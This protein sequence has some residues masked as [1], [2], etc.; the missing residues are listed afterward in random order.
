[1]WQVVMNEGLHECPWMCYDCRLRVT[2]MMEGDPE[3]GLFIS[4]LHG[5]RQ[6]YVTG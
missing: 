2:W 1:M 5:Q 3:S 4:A 6:G